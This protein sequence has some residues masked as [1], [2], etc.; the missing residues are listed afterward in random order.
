MAPFAFAVFIGAFLLFLVQPLAGRFV[1]PWFG[2]SA[3]VWTVCLLFFQSALFVGYLYAHALGRL[4]SLRQQV[5]LHLGLLA[6]AL[7]W[8]PPQLTAPAAEVLV[9]QPARSLIVLLVKDLGPLFVLLSATGPLLQSWFHRA[10]PHRSPYLLYA[11]SNVGSL[12]GLLVY[13]FLIEPVWTRSEQAAFWSGGFIVFIG[14]LA[15]CA[16]HVLRQ[17]SPTPRS[18][19]DHETDPIDTPTPDVARLMRWLGL[20]ALGTALLAA[21]T[22]ALTVDISPVPFLWVAPLA[23]YLLSFIATFAERNFYRP[24]LMFSLVVLAAALCMDLRSFGTQMRFTPFLLSHLFCLAVGCTWSHGELY[25]HRPHP[26]HLT[27]FYLTIS[28]GG[29]LGTSAVALVAPTVFNVDNDLPIIWSAAL[30][31]IGIQAWRQSSP[32]AARALFAGM[33]A[34]ILLVPLLRPTAGISVWDNLIELLLHQWALLVLLGISA[35]GVVLSVWMKSASRRW[36]TRTAVLLTVGNAVSF[37]NFTAWSE[38]PGTVQTLRGF[39]GLITV[40]DYANEDPR[41]SA[42]YM[43]HGTTTH[44]IQLLHEA[45]RH[46]PTSYYTPSGGIGRALIRENQSANRHIGVI[47]LGVGTVAAYGMPGDVLR[48]FEI[49]ENVIQIAQEDFSFLSHTP[50]EVQIVS[51]DGRLM[52]EQELTNPTH[53]PYD[54]LVLDAFSGDAV[55][56]HLLTQEAFATYVALLEPTG[57]IA[58]NISNRLIDLRPIVEGNARDSSLYLV[59]VIHHP[60]VE[61]WWQFPSEWILLAPRHET[62]DTPAITSYTGI[63]SPAEL[64]PVRWTD[65]YSSILPNLR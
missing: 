21:T 38:A 3:G 5:G 45:Y 11:L 13:P 55:P 32:S 65:E 1:L 53:R 59:H 56:T 64:G 14:V 60:G 22:T 16:I 42:R 29:A 28:L 34:A 48:F 52:L 44:G 62:L 36:F 43:S 46:Y 10:R 31:A 40:T 37:Y 26:R 50:S 20:A 57:V 63:A 24:M 30:V 9:E 49:D 33:I 47:G 51:G 25:R 41:A 2:G 17:L 27:L 4:Q 18:D 6:G 39:H 61:D 19:A 12:L 8:L 54:L 23:V 15:W 58:V 7:L 35:L